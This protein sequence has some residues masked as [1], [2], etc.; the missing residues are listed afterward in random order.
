MSNWKNALNNGKEGELLWKEYLELRNHDVIMSDD[1]R[2]NQLLFWDI[3]TNDGTRFEVKYDQKAWPY[4]HS[5]DW[6]KS[7]NL[8]LEYWSTTRDEKCG[9]YSLLGNSDIFVYI[10]KYIDEH[11]VHKSNYAHVFYVE[12]LIEWCERKMFKSARCSATGDDNAIGWL[13]PESDVV[14]D[15]LHNGY[16]N[17][18]E[19]RL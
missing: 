12:P 2:G 8:F 10:M 15:A 4:Y 13:V 9:M 1:V 11:G 6:Q 19:L 5:K 16:I 3:E 14:N 7:P 17:R 18:V